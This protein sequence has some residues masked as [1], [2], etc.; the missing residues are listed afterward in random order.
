MYLGGRR[1]RRWLDLGVQWSGGWDGGL[2]ALGRVDRE[3]GEQVALGLGELGGLAEDAGRAGE[4]DGVQP[5][6]LGADALPGLPGGVLRD[7]DEQQRQPAQQ[8]V[9]PPANQISTAWV[10]GAAGSAA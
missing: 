3:R 10:V 8:Y 2:D 1:P 4:G 9:T 6:G 5:V 7:A